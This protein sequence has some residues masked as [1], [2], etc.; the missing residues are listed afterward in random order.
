MPSA[1]RRTA[2]QRPSSVQ[3]ARICALRLPR[4]QISVTKSG[5]AKPESRDPCHRR[6]SEKRMARVGKNDRLVPAGLG[7]FP[8]SGRFRDLLYVV[9]SRTGRGSLTRRDG[10]SLSGLG[11]GVSLGNATK[12]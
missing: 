8:G 6:A 5:S 10:P 1:R 7:V 2:W 3:P 9:L 4:R 12:G 11:R